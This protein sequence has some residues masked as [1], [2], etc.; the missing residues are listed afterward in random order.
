MKKCWRYDFS[1]LFALFDCYAQLDE[2]DKGPCLAAI[3][4]ISANG[5]NDKAGISVARDVPISATANQSV[6]PMV[7]DGN[8]PL[9]VDHD[10]SCEDLVPIV[11]HWINI[12]ADPTDSQFSGGRDGHGRTFVSLHDKTLDPSNGLKHMAHFYAY[13]LHRARETCGENAS[14]KRLKEAFSYKA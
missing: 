4:A 10:W 14:E 6:R 2:E 3:Y 7:P 1:V 12:S 9:T 11:I 8:V 13:L 5:S